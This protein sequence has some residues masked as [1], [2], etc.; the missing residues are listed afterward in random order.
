MF[1]S[2]LLM[3]A[4]KRREDKFLSF[5]SCFLIDLAFVG[6]TIARLYEHVLCIFT[7]ICVWKLLRRS[8]IQVDILK[9]QKILKVEFIFSRCFIYSSVLHWQQTRVLFHLFLSEVERDALMENGWASNPLFAKPLT[10]SSGE[11][12][13]IQ[14]STYSSSMHSTCTSPRP[15]CVVSAHFFWNDRNSSQAPD[16]VIL[17]A[18]TTRA[19]R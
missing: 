14:L 17:S 6:S 19:M 11:Q 3:K 2:I 12:F 1:F 9:L 13:V 7:S 18:P 16:R 15:C 8:H 10:P 5:F 4:D